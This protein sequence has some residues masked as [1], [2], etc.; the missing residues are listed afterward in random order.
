MATRLGLGLPQNRQYDLG[1]DVPDVAR[2]A[3]GIGYDSL[4]VYER[5][6]FPEPATQG[7]YGIEGLPW[8]DSYRHVADPLVTLTLAAAATE[9][10][11]LGTSVLVAPLH[12]PF[13]LAR[14]LASLDAASGGRV[15]AGFGTGWSLD[16]YA[17]SG[18]RP[19]KERGRVLDEV[20][21]V[22][23]A[24]WGPDPVRHHGPTTEIDS[25]VVGPKPAR[26]IPVLLAAG[27]RRA[28]ERLVEHADGWLPT[29]V[30]IDE[31]AA[32]WHALQ[33]LAAERGR[34]QPIR[35]VLRANA[36]YS[37]KAHE[38]AD[39]PPFHGSADQIVEDLFGYVELGMQ[40]VL[41]D[42]QSTLRDA[43]ELKD[44]AAEVHEKA[45]AA[46]L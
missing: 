24:V 35:T 12:V 19:I 38:G 40:E 43:E 45:R 29:S 8:P 16:E 7:L 21:D 36:R 1:K 32:Q 10:V 2:T 30:G 31:V 46:G 11:G 5:A 42:L 44:V 9:R 39:R 28:R 6:L 33:D 18:I 22:C 13:Q 17:A 3:E 15:I 25:A 4:W 41:V 14:T 37:A 26:P 34:Q 20:I 27:T 23:R